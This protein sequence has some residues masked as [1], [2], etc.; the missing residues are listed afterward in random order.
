MAQHDFNIANQGFPAFRSDLNNALSATVSLSSGS[1]QPSTMFAYQLWYDTS[2]NIIKQRNADNDAWINLFAVNQT[3]D[4]AS[5][6][7]IDIVN[8]TTP[9]LG[10]NLDVNTKNI[11]FGDSGGASDDRLA[12]GAGTDLSIYHDSTDSNIVNAT[13]EL[14]IKGDG[15]TLLSNT[16]GEE[17]ITCD[18]NGAVT[19]YHN[20]VIKAAT[21]ANGLS[22]TGTA[23]ATTDTDTS[24]SGTVTLDFA[25]NQNFVLTITGAVTLAN[26]TTEQ[27]GQSGFI[28]FIQDGSGGATISL[29]TQYKTSGGVN[30]LT[31]SSAASA[32]DVVPYIVS[33][34]DSI[35]L[36]TPQLNFS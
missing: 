12:F 14:N 17:Y 6:S 22:I 3:T 8:D 29:D 9:Q 13:G 19:L 7:T 18:V 10:G 16:S 25:T 21:T 32:L 4:T 31:L 26:P 11:V 2:N 34:A 20:D 23:V 30:T 15:I 1:S 36:G 28:V 35:L 27:V 24:N 5:P 33:A